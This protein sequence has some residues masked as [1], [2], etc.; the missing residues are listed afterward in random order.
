MSSQHIGHRKLLVVRWFALLLAHQNRSHKGYD[1]KPLAKENRQ[2]ELAPRDC[3][4]SPGDVLKWKKQQ[5]LNKQ[6]TTT[7]LAIDDLTMLLF[8]LTCCL[9]LVL[10]CLLNNVLHETQQQ[11]SNVPSTA[12]PFE[13]AELE[14]YMWETGCTLRRQKAAR[15]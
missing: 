12:R 9:L 3:L 7:I 2:F 8:M 5:Q 4:N 10:R 14:C 6:T 11:F 15:C 13:A 1:S